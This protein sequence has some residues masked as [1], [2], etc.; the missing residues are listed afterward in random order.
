MAGNL[1]KKI[2]LLPRK[3]GIYFF[4]NKEKETIYIGKARSLKERVKSYL[5]ATSDPKISNILAETADVEFILTDSERE[6]AFLENNFVRRYQPKFNL[7]LKDDKSFPYLKLTAQERFPGI[8][9]TRRVEPDGARYFGPFSPAHQARTTIHLINKHFGIRACTEDVPGKRKRPCLEYDLK[10]CSAPCLDYISEDEYQE[11]VKH[12]LLFL[13]GHVQELLKILKNKMRKAAAGQEFEQAA[14]WRDTIRAIEQIKEKPKLISVR[15]EDLDIF[16]FSRDQERA[17]FYIFLMRRGKVIES[18]ELMFQEKTS[19]PDKN[20]LSSFLTK[21]YEGREEKPA[22]ILLPFVPAE[23]EALSKVLMAGVQKKIEITVPFRGKNKKLVELANK[24][25]EFL[26]QKKEKKFSPLEEIKNILSLESLPRR[27]EGF[28]I[29]N[30][31]GEESVGSLVV[32]ENGQPKKSDYRKYKIKTVTGPND[33]ASLQEVIRRRYERVL[34]EQKNLPELILV[35]GGK[36]QLSAARLALQG[37]GVD[38]IPVVSLA[39]REEILYTP[40]RKEGLRLDRTSSALKLIQNIRD[41]AHRFAIA[42]H[43]QRR[44]KRSFSSLLDGIAGV[45]EKKRK[46]LL[47]KYKSIREIRKAPLEDLARIAGAKAAEALKE[48]ANTETQ[49]T[50]T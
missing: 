8:Y 2:D 5:Q 12:A 37:L 26:L 1:K 35:D 38:N 40:S 29:S 36:G 23:K 43:R 30:L 18:E 16:G 22:K 44:K 17:A 27:I 50:E 34:R 39:K 42:F 10:L 47:T 21:F 15:Q 41:E 6:A 19:I 45:G 24:N 48:R 25:A 3:P 14:H 20:I 9:L 28:D 49:E 46:I 7:K 11:N 33:V 13:E 4:K 31:S 32:F